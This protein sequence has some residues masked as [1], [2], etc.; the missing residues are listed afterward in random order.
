M[1]VFF[2]HAHM[3][4]FCEPRMRIIWADFL[5][6]HAVE[7]PGHCFFFLELWAQRP[8]TDKTIGHPV[9][10]DRLLLHVRRRRVR[11]NVMSNIS[12]PQASG[13]WKAS[14]RGMSE[15]TE[16]PSMSQRKKKSIP[17]Q[18]CNI[19]IL[20]PWEKCFRTRFVLKIGHKNMLVFVSEGF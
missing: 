19:L 4:A 6:F 18:N 8:D 15:K 11:L 10:S 17:S 2:W 1:T 12:R 14:Q 7:L 13:W 9:L 5:F 16:L 3:H 20:F